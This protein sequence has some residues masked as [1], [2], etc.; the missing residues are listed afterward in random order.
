MGLWGDT[1]TPIKGDHKWSPFHLISIIMNIYDSI[2]DTFNKM[3]KY[4][5]LYDTWIGRLYHEDG[6]MIEE[7]WNNNNWI[8]MNRDIKSMQILFTI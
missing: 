1:L 8:K 4:Q 5:G 7:E 6:T 3:A 2:S